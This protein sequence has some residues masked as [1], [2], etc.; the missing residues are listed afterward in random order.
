MT[1]TGVSAQMYENMFAHRFTADDKDYQE[2]LKKE[3]DH[4]PIV[5]DWKAGNQRN[6]DRYRDNRRRGW[7]PRRNWSSNSYQPY[8]GGWGNNYNQYRHERSYYSQGRYTHNPN[9][10]T[11]YTDHF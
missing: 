10:E 8:G 9:D 7:E 4:P 5:E 3:P 11:F 6:N 1:E 2:Y